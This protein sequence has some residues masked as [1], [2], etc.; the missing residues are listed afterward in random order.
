MDEGGTVDNEGPHRGRSLGGRGAGLRVPQ[1][2]PHR[3]AGV[4]E[5][6]LGPVVPALEKLT[7]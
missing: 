3:S 1:A 4:A 6:K 7:P 5:A 2:V